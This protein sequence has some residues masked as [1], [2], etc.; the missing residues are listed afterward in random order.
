MKNDPISSI[1]CMVNGLEC[2]LMRET[3]LKLQED[4]N[5]SNEMLVQ[6]AIAWNSYLDIYVKA[7]NKIHKPTI[8]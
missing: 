6:D 1:L 3:F 4:E 7:Y 2:A 8:Q 5:A